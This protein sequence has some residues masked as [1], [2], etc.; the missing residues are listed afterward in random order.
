MELYFLDLNSTYM[1][2]NLLYD[3]GKHA[4]GSLAPKL[5]NHFQ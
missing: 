4:G 3:N 2:E 1:I 5:I